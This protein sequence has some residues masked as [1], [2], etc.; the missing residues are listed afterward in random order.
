MDT[1][2]NVT[3][4]ALY[5][6]VEAASDSSGAVSLILVFADPVNPPI[7]LNPGDTVTIVYKIILP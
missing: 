1:A 2:Y 4:T 7:Q 6:A 5:F 3:A